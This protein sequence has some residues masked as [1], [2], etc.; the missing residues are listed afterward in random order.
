MKDL[1]FAVH[2]NTQ[3]SD[4]QGGAGVSLEASRNG[5]PF[6]FGQWGFA[7]QEQGKTLKAQGQ[8]TE[9]CVCNDNGCEYLEIDLALSHGCRLQRFFL[10]DQDDQVLILGDTVLSAKKKG[11]WSYQSALHH[12]P[13]VRFDGTTFHT[14]KNKAL[15]RS[16]AL[17]GTMD[18]QD[19]MLRVQ[20][21]STGQAFFVSMFFDLKSTRLSKPFLCQQLT[22]GEDR[23]PVPAERAVGYRI[24]RAQEQFLLYK[25]MTAQANRTVLG[26]NL[27][28][29]L[30]FARFHRKD[31]VKPLVAVQTEE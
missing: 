11:D 10:F 2:Y 15:F 22:V 23:Q 26:H 3:N 21:Q 19:S 5:L 27:I 13:E 29:D 7:V 1:S 24:Q 12:S 9:I 17:N 8:W 16:I 4:T 14:A 28:D 6:L 31:G 25:S 18:S 30:C 20:H